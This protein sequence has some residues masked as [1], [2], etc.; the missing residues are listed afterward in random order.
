M[1]PV[2]DLILRCGLALLFLVA[3]IHKLR[4]PVHF[5]ATLIDYRIV[6]GGAAGLVAWL[7]TGAELAIAAALLA[8][9]LHAAGPAGAAGLLALYGLAI[10]V[11]LARGRRHID[12][13]CAGPALRRPISG[14]LV[15]RNGVLAAVALLALRPVAAR[16]LFWVDALTVGAAL[17]SASALYVAVDRMLGEAPLRGRLWSEP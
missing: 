14:A 1:D 13:G 9:G 5:R 11:N 6:P 7:V 3:A 17:L 15:A 10:A 8:P 2:I 16:Q 12:C 4:D